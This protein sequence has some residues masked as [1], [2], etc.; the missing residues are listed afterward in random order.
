VIIPVMVRRPGASTHPVIRS[1]KMAKLG[2][3]NPA[4]ASSSSAVH[5]F[6]GPGGPL[7]ARRGRPVR[8]WLPVRA[9]PGHFGYLA[10]R[11]EHRVAILHRLHHVDLVRLRRA[12]WAIRPKA[13][14][15]VDKVTWAEYGQDLEANLQ[16]LHVRVQQVGP[17]PCSANGLT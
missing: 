7:P 8:R 5:P 16:D 2:V 6:T 17:R 10:T 9:W 11:E 4:R 13:A 15:G 3:V 1:V 12:Y 14:P